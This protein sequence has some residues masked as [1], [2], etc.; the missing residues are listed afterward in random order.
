M[1][2]TWLRQKG[3]AHLILF[4]SG[5]AVSTSPIL[6]LAGDHDLLVLGDYRDEGLPPLPPYARITV[7]AYS[8]GV[9]VAAR[10]L[11]RLK[12]HRAVAIC[13]TPDP[14][15]TIGPAIYDGTIAGLNQQ[16]LMQFARRA[17][18]PLPPRPDIQALAAELRA[19]DARRPAK[20]P[21]F[22]RIIAA[23]QDRIFPA[24]AL[25][26]AW[27]DRQIDWC[28]GGHSPFRTLAKLA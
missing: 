1:R 13:G 26:K 5:W 24:S 10:L 6:H 19:L 3:H 9:A 12:A 8:M 15:D 27:P 14:R 28:E 7:A 11:P 4:F 25:A 17:C 22:D 21:A 18:A 16:R 20:A 2:A 23:R